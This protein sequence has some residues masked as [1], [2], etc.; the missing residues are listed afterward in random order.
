[1]TVPLN[2]VLPIARIVKNGPEH[3]AMARM[4]RRAKAQDAQIAQPEAPRSAPVPIAV[5][6][7]GA[8]G[9][10][11]LRLGATGQAEAAKVAV[12]VP[13]EL[14]HPGKKGPDPIEAVPPSAKAWTGAQGPI[15]PTTRIEDR[16]R[17]AVT[18]RTSVMSAL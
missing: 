2:R 14:P 3:R 1:M 5:R 10:I 8:E 11:A 9:P 17:K 12:Q 6:P 18:A 15:A 4:C 7:R 13:R 16:A